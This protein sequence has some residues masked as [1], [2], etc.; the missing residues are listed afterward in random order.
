M[1][2]IL[3]GRPAGAGSQLSQVQCWLHYQRMGCQPQHWLCHALQ[4][5]MPNCE[6][7]W[8]GNN[9]SNWKCVSTPP[10]GEGD[11]ALSHRHNGPA[12]QS[13]HSLAACSTHLQGQNR[14]SAFKASMRVVWQRSEAR[15]STPVLQRPQCTS[16]GGLGLHSLVAAC[17]RLSCS[18]HWPCQLS[19]TCLLVS[20][21]TQDEP[22]LCAKH[23][24]DRETQH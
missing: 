20:P 17:R 15:V 24:H 21:G 8:C 12:A 14:T 10:L 3:K 9:S 16:V 23:C 19:S 13:R 5:T 22:A 4:R 1:L 2:L 11:G 6:P 18:R 7:P